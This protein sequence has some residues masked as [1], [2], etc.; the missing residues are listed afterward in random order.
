MN[1]SK[2]SL[3]TDHQS[4]TNQLSLDNVLYHFRA[5]LAQK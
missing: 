4:S 5:I 2:I 3:K 1:V